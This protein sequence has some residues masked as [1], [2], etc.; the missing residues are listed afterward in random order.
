MVIEESD[1]FQCLVRFI[2]CVP[3][4]LQIMLDFANFSDLAVIFNFILISLELP[5]Q[6]LVK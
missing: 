5:C 3:Q 2:I 4:S 1:E 6:Y